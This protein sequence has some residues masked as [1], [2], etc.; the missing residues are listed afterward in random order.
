[1]DKEKN[2]DQYWNTPLEPITV[3]EHNCNVNRTKLL[4]LINFSDAMPMYNEEFGPHLQICPKDS[5][6][7][8]VPL[9]G[10]TCSGMLIKDQEK[11]PDNVFY[12]TFVECK[13]PIV[14]ALIKNTYKK[15]FEIP[16]VVQAI[17]VPEL[18][19]RRDALVQFKSGTG[20]THAFLFG[21]LWGFD[22]N[23]S[24][25]QYVFITNSH[26]VA[27]QIYDRAKELVPENT[28]ISLCIGQKK[29]VTVAGGFKSTISTSTLSGEGIGQNIQCDKSLHTM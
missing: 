8:I 23:D 19:Q 15:G 2:S 9:T 24:A 5:P 18:I 28:K 20:K 25:L 7:I 29:D 11:M 6:P 12:K 22:P 13:R 27:K 3:G 26:E 4:P 14:E 1:M 17:A 16:S 21:L 10:P